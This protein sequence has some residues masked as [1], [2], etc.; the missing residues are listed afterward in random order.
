M[1]C[2]QCG[3]ALPDDADFC[4]ECGAKQE[5]N[6]A[7][8]N[9]AMGGDAQAET[10]LYNGTYN[11]VYALI[12]SMIRDEDT[13]LDLLQDSYVKAF[14]NLNQLH[15]ANRFRA[16]VKTIARNRTMDHFRER[17]TVLFS[18]MTPLDDDTS[19]IEI[20][21]TDP[22]SMPEVVI[23][24]QE[25]ARLIAEILDA[26]PE[27]QRGVIAM[28]YYEQ[29]SVREIANHLGISQ[30]TVLS[31]LRY[32]RQ[33]I[34]TNVLALE[35]K[36]TKLYGLAAIPF[37]V[38]LLRKQE[39]YAMEPSEAAS[40]LTKILKTLAGKG[41]AAK[42][43]LKKG[44]G[45]ADGGLKAGLKAGSA[46]DAGLKAGGAAAGTGGTGVAVGVAAKA[47]LSAGVKLLIA[48]AVATGVAAI[49]AGVIF[50]VPPVRE[51]V[52]PALGIETSFSR[53]DE[54]AENSI[55]GSIGENDIAFSPVRLE[56]TEYTITSAVAL[57]WDGTDMDAE[58]LQTSLTENQVGEFLAKL[59]YNESFVTRS[60]ADEEYLV[61]Y[62]GTYNLQADL[63]QDKVDELFLSLF[64][65]K[66][67]YSRLPEEPSSGYQYTQHGAIY[68]DGTLTTWNRH[69]FSNEPTTTVEFEA[70]RDLED[71]TEMLYKLYEHGQGEQN[72][73]GTI[74]IRLKPAN[75]SCGFRVDGIYLTD[76]VERDAESPESAYDEVIAQYRSL[77]QEPFV[78]E[79]IEDWK[80]EYPLALGYAEYHAYN[81][82]GRWAP[83]LSAAPILYALYDLNGDGIREMMVVMD[84]FAQG[85]VDGL[86]NLTETY[87]S[88]YVL[89][90][91]LTVRFGVVES[92][93]HGFV[94][95][96]LFLREDGTICN[97]TLSRTGPDKIY[98]WELGPRGADMLCV[99]DKESGEVLNTVQ[100]HLE[101][102]LSEER[103]KAFTAVEWDDPAVPASIHPLNNPSLWTPLR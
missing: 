83:S 7:L 64:G 49:A 84:P 90:D 68:K 86:S 1:N 70:Y 61:L 88:H 2:I 74:A 28:F 22:Q 27:D 78:F 14:R 82:S 5:F 33:K 45:A 59:S 15:E 44:A 53:N 100:P 75:N 41:D 97:I 48:L 43:G 47:G 94:T 32:G 62:D 12:K 16:W 85:T 60:R 11:T 103:I 51:R 6:Q 50:A 57:M 76:R 77:L 98:V 37:L 63:D 40:I 73:T 35:K 93:L 80:K 81:G 67:D 20:E 55:A 65:L 69:M 8:I 23:D 17:K 25:T 56:G 101:S 92:L 3:T 66:Y 31:R 46:A 19:E 95:S 29:M 87:E 39:A 96:R 24:R 91:V 36:G 4:T 52:L 10:V 42:S 99:L 30:N 79:S 26:L 13:V 38:L 21:D 54:D 89:I 72:Y 58:M 102:R 18:D 34:E 71:A 9:R